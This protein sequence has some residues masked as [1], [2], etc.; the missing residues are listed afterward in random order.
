MKN[1]VASGIRQMNRELEG[2]D[3]GYNRGT[4]GEPPRT[5]GRIA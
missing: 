3:I 4:G 1:P 2:G 5:P